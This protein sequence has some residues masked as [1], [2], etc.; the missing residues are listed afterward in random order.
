[1]SESNKAKDTAEAVKA[2]VEAVPVYQDIVQ[3]AAKEI[4]G[5]AG[6]VVRMALAPIKMLVWGFDKICEW[7][8]PELEERLKKVPQARIITPKTTVAG[9]ALE[10]LRFAGNESSLREMYANL[11]AKAMDSETASI[12]H[13]AFVEILRQLVPDEAKLLQVLTKPGKLFPLL[14]VASE[15]DSPKGRGSITLFRHLSTLGL[16]AGCH[17]PRLTTQYIENLCRLGVCEIPALTGYTDKD[18]YKELENRPEIQNLRNK[19]DSN[20][21][22]KSVIF[23][24]MLQLTAFGRLFCDACVT[25]LSQ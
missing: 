1:M 10:A 16:E 8:T 15:I 22:Q 14:S 25:P 19:I 23:Y 17:E 9:P 20:Q 7:L 24:E 18:I 21:G 3:P 2:L 4:G 5:V 6:D 12:A 11:L 13:P